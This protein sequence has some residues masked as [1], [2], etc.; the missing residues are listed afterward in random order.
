MACIIS[1]EGRNDYEMKIGKKKKGQR[2][3]KMYLRRNPSVH[4]NGKR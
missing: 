1:V 3:D 4:D 2:Q